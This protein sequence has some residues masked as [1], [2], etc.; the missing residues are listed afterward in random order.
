M[1][2]DLKILEIDAEIVRVSSE[3]ETLNERLKELMNARKRRLDEMLLAAESRLRF[4]S[5][6]PQA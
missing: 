4:D 2:A 5:P 1:G 6:R 3:I